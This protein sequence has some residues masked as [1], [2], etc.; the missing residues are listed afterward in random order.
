MKNPY[1]TVWFPKEI[2]LLHQVS[3]F[4][5]RMSKLNN[6]YWLETDD[7]LHSLCQYKEKISEGV[8]PTVFPYTNLPQVTTTYH[9][10]KFFH[11]LISCRE[12]I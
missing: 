4:V 3:D 5:G 2:C 10:W 11:K 8:K 9:D 12:P 1:T 6:R 7:F